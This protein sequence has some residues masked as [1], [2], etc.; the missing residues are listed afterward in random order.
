[1][2]YSITNKI[3]LGI[4]DI[5]RYIIGIHPDSDDLDQKII[6]PVQIITDDIIKNISGFKTLFSLESLSLLYMEK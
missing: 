3:T 6:I 2:K 5:I 4:N 1:M